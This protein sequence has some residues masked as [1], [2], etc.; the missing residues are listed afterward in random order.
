MPNC[1]IDLPSSKCQLLKVLMIVLPNEIMYLY[2][3]E[4]E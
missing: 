3:D 2:S 1:V 4:P